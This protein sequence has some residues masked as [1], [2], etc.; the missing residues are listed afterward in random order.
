[1]VAAAPVPAVP[2]DRSHSVSIGTS[3]SSE[4]FFTV[5][6]SP[7]QQLLHQQHHQQQTAPGA[8]I[9][10]ASIT[11]RRSLSPFVSSSSP[12]AGRRVPPPIRTTS[13]PVPPHVTSPAV[14]RGASSG[15]ASS[16]RR[17]H[18]AGS[19]HVP[20]TSAAAS[21][22]SAGIK[23][24]SR[25]RSTRSPSFGVMW[26]RNTPRY[27]R[28]RSVTPT[29]GAQP[30]AAWATTEEQQ[31]HQSRQQQ[32]IQRVRGTTPFAYATPFSTG[33]D[34]CPPTSASSLASGSGHRK[35]KRQEQHDRQERQLQYRRNSRHGSRGPMPAVFGHANNGQN[36]YDDEDMMM[37]G[38]DSDDIDD[39]DFPMTQDDE[40][41]DDDDADDIEVYEDEQDM[42][43]LG[44][45]DDGHDNHDNHHETGRQLLPKDQP[46]PG[47]EFDVDDVDE[48]DGDNEDFIGHTFGGRHHHGS[49]QDTHNDEDESMFDSENMD[50]L[51]ISLFGDH[52]AEDDLQSLQPP[53]QQ[54]HGEENNSD[55]SSQPSEYPSTRRPWRLGPVSA[56]V[57]ASGHAKNDVEERKHVD[58]E[59]DIGFKI[60]EDGDAANL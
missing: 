49:T 31:S 40:D 24:R 19:N 22:L 47:I 15:A 39:F 28:S 23:K 30:M 44:S 46:Q 36:Y 57:Y 1:M 17:V 4:Q 55:H 58:D 32:P 26:P 45:N 5:A 7:M 8:T 51:S 13:M 3:G 52:N 48:D 9:P 54:E 16:R 38:Y 59:V 29:P 21:P 20:A 42:L 50:P 12:S 27:S 6:Q 43:G 37:V 18:S 11:L 41:D 35:R 33:A 2:A 53:P 10:T 56:A 34:H 25:R 60:H 14:M